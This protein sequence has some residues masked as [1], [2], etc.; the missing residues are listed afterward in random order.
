MIIYSLPSSAMSENLPSGAV[1]ALGF[2]DGV[3]LGH[4]LII[5]TAR[6]EADRRG[7]VPCVWMISS[8][9]KEYKSGSP[10]LV[11]ESEKSNLLYEAGARFAA[12]YDFSELRNLDGEHF[13]SEIL[14]R[15]LGASCVVCGFNFRFGKGASW[16]V[17][18]LTRICMKHGIDVVVSDAVTDEAGEC[19]SST[20]IRQLISEGE[21]AEAALML[22]RPYS[23]TSTVLEG[24]RL[25]RRLGFPT[26]NQLPED[27][28]LMP[29]RGVYAVCAEFELDGKVYSY[30]G[31]ANVGFCPTLAR[32]EAVSTDANGTKPHSIGVASEGH[33]VCE[34]YIADFSGDLYG[35]TVKIMF[36]ER[37]RGETR[38]ASVDELKAQ[39]GNDA[40]RAVKIYNEI[41]GKGKND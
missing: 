3:H 2:F 18:D 24:K 9:D 32:T 38:F 22:G 15:E 26:V 35:K 13:V 4:R 34:T 33:A 19:I 36:L 41:Y 21:V 14:K 31:A 28:R 30:P 1:I 27:G 11:C 10:Y 23:F 12:V 29:K 37:L 16:D 5:D 20:R 17:C 8:G 7:A 39:I 40:E 6:R 25:G